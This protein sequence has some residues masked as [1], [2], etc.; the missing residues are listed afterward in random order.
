MIVITEAE[1]KRV[2]K[3]R[4]EWYVLDPK[5]DD[6]TMARMSPGEIREE[7]R[8]GVSCKSLGGAVVRGKMP[9]ESGDSWLSLKYI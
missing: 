4:F 8:T 5:P 2:L 3:G 7:V 9:I 1:R 6:L